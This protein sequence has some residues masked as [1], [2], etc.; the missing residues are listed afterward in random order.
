MC[1]EIF[2]VFY[3]INS[4]LVNELSDQTTEQQVMVSRLKAT[5]KE[6]ERLKGQLQQ[7]VQE[8]ERAEDLL[9]RKV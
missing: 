8:V 9:M 1:N 5:E 3:V 7:Y 4:R 6:V 2:P